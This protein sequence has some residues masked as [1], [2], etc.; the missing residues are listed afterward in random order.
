MGTVHYGSAIV[1][2]PPE[3][4]ANPVIALEI[5]DSLDR[6][7]A[8]KDS[9]I[10]FGESLAEAQEW[11]E[12][13][14]IIDVLN[15]DSDPPFP[16]DLHD[17]MVRGESNGFITSVRGRLCWL[18]QKIVVYNRVASYSA[19]LDIVE[20]YA[21]GQ[22]LYIR[23]QSCVPLL[24]MAVR[25]RSRLPEGGR[26]MPEEF[27][28]RIKR[29]A[30]ERLRD[31]REYTALLEHVSDFFVWIKDLSAEEVLEVLQR[32]EPCDGRNGVHNRCFVLLQAAL[33]RGNEFG[34]LPA[35]DRDPFVSELHQELRDGPSRFRTSLMWQMAGGADE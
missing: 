21:F 7:P 6:I 33:F 28:E 34:D 31:S 15:D 18:I 27:A 10:S 13:L 23:S 25:R 14:W 1:S 3:D 35:F 5:S 20:T 12:V 2:I 9:L 26:F 22:D 19:M 16:N 24:E 4:T 8:S 29:N 30:F 11:P 17:R 32:L